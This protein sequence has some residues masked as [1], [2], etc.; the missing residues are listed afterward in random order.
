MRRAHRQDREDARRRRARAGALLGHR[1]QGARHGRRARRGAS[2]RATPTR[3]PTRSS[4]PAAPPSASS[5][6]AHAR[7]LPSTAWQGAS[8]VV[9]MRSS[10][11][12]CSSWPRCGGCGVAAAQRRRS[13]RRQGICPG[14]PDQCGGKCCGATCIDVSHDPHNCGD[15][16]TV[17]PVGTVCLGGSC[18]C[19]PHGD[20][21]SLGQIVLRRARLRQPR[22][23]HPQLRRLRHALP[24]RRHL[25]G[26]HVHAAPARACSA[27][28]R[29]DWRGLGAARLLQLLRRLRQRS[30]SAAASP[31]TA[32]T[33]TTPAGKLHRRRRAAATWTVPMTMKLHVNVDHVATLR[34]ARGTPLSR[35]GVGGVAR[36]SSPAPTASPCTCAKIAGTSRIA[37]CAS[38]ARRCAA[39]STW[40]WRPPTRWSRIAREIKPDVVSLVPEKRQERT[41][42][43]GLDVAGAARAGVAEAIEALVGDGIAGQPVHRS[44]RRRRS[45]RPRSWA[46]RASSCTPAT[47]ASAWH[48]LPN[49]RGATRS[50]RACERA[51][52]ARRRARAARRR[53]PRPRLRQRRRRSPP[54]ARSSELN[55]G[56]AIVARAVLVGMERAV[57][58]MRAAIERVRAADAT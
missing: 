20:K 7:A 51:A 12:L 23:R 53:R 40:R 56:H 21:C 46:R 36:A 48:G 5:P 47:T 6:T 45:R 28:G 13:A 30:D 1:G 44:D 26:R 32:A 2:S 15:C 37:T 33:P 41:T 24:R 16:G 10:S 11:S 54:S 52:R 35:S 3:S 29:P 34:Q 39:C 17:C 18:G 49:A 14:H 19:P 38:C 42:E 27:D 25:H 31:W 22:Q 9:A 8:V 4:R 55:I 50:W 58:E 43:G 57:R